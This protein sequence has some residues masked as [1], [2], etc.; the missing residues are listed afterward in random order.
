MAGSSPPGS[1]HA[2]VD[3]PVPPLAFGGARPGC[4]R[5]ARAQRLVLAGPCPQRQ[6]RRCVEERPQGRP[7][8]S[9]GAR[10]A[11]RLRGAQRPV[12]RG[13]GV[14][15]APLEG[16]SEASRRSSAAPRGRA[17]TAVRTD[18]RFGAQAGP[19]GEEGGRGGE[20]CGAVRRGGAARRSRARVLPDARRRSERVAAGAGRARAHRPPLAGRAPLQAG[21]GQDPHLS[22]GGIRQWERTRRAPGAERSSGL[23]P[24]TPRFRSCGPTSVLIPP[25]R[26][27]HDAS[28]APGMPRR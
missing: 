6:G 20:I 8:Q 3:L 13:K 18:A 5:A 19:R 17:G 9:R 11:G 26:R 14:P 2:R 28:T 16:E 12:R 22:R 7:R 27:S 10:G 21:A 15:R 4:R 23:H 24:T 1:R 25:T